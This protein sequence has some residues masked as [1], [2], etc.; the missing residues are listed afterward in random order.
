MIIDS[1][2]F[3]RYAIQKHKLST[4][5]ARRLWLVSG[6]SYVGRLL[7]LHYRMSEK[8]QE[9]DALLKSM[10]V[11]ALA[12]FDNVSQKFAVNEWEQ[13]LESLEFVEQTLES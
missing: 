2:E 8:V 10:D 3:I 1:E 9:L 13:A 6:N 11:E 5:Q 4:S 7:Y 12:D